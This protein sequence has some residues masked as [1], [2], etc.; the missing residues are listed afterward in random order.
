MSAQRILVEACNPDPHN[1]P[2]LGVWQ[3]VD[4]VGK[5]MYMLSSAYPNIPG[6]VCDSWCYES[7]AAFVEARAETGGRVMITHR[8]NGTQDVFIRTEITPEP[9]VVDVCIWI[10]CQGVRI[11]PADRDIPPPNLC[12]QLKRSPGFSS[13]PDFYLEF[14][15]RCFIFTTKGRM[16]L[17]RTERLP[18]AG[19]P[20][21]DIRNNPPW[22]QAYYPLGSG[23]AGS[24]DRFTHPV[25]GTVSRDRRYLTAIA[26]E[27][28]TSL[29]QMW[30]DCMHNIPECLPASAPPEEQTW[31][32]RIYAME[33]DPDALLKRVENDFSKMR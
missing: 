27:K 28:S 18:H 32:L 2:S 25:I 9:S 23:D 19:T 11:N 7:G 13:K 12:W 14:V 4:D 31:R 16:F 5:V 33:N 8:L 17:D 3:R 30:H 1:L 15:S 6:F 21:D 26:C 10:E 24:R 22:V 29:S 20:A